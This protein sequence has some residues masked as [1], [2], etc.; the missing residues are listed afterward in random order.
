VLPACRYVAVCGSSEADSSLRET[1][2]EV[3]RLLAEAGVVVL[4]GGLGGVMEAAS[5][6]ATPV[7]PV[8]LALG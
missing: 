1:A 8:R 3:G 5:E 2:H 6:A 7:D 4:C